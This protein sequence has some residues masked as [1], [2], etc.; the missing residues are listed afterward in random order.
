MFKMKGSW[1]VDEYWH[2][3][4]FFILA[5]FYCS[6]C[7]NFVSFS[8]ARAFHCQCVGSFL[9]YIPPTKQSAK[10]VFG[11]QLTTSR[12]CLAKLC[13]KCYGLIYL[14][15]LFLAVGVG[16]AR[17]ATATIDFPHCFRFSC[18][19]FFRAFFGCCLTQRLL[20]M[21]LAHISICYN[22]RPQ[23]KEGRCTLRRM[24]RGWGRG[25]G[26]IGEIGQP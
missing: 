5:N 3:I 15:G 18:P 17:V 22:S 4:A 11:A 7:Q 10:S 8:F 23:L 14:L 13:R 1:R 2:L 12:S 26:L 20:W 9:Q 19:L 25:G 6:K 21:N 24:R 16:G